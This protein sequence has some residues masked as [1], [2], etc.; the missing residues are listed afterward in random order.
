M[1][2]PVLNQADAPLPSLEVQRAAV[3]ELKRLANDQGMGE[4]LDSYRFPERLYWLADPSTSSL[5]DLIE[6]VLFDPCANIWWGPLAAAQAVYENLRLVWLDNL[7]HVNAFGG[8]VALWEDGDH[9]FVGTIFNSD[10]AGSFDAQT[11]QGL[12][13]VAH[14]RF[15]CHATELW[16][17]FRTRGTPAFPVEVSAGDQ[18]RFLESLR[19]IVVPELHTHID[20]LLAETKSGE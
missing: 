5:E 2:T 6:G 9:A 14:D 4:L 15:E 7:A 1:T 10:T 19:T 17:N 11:S 3:K 16:D 8:L 13:P 18:H 20:D 12:V